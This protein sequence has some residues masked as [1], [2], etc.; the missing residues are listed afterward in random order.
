MEV[1][2]GV[3]DDVGRHTGKGNGQFREV[4]G[5]VVGRRKSIEKGEDVLSQNESAALALRMIAEVEGLRYDVSILLRALAQTLMAQVLPIREHVRPVL[6]P[7]HRVELLRTVA[8]GVEAAH[9]T[10]HRGASDDVDGHAGPLQNFQD[11]DVGNAL[12]AAPTQHQSQTWP[13]GGVGF[14]HFDF[15]TAGGLPCNAFRQ[16]EQ[17]QEKWYK[18]FH[19]ANV[20]KKN[21]T[22]KR[23]T[24]VFLEMNS[25]LPASTARS[26]AAKAATGTVAT[27]AATGT[28]ATIAA[29]ASPTL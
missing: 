25:I 13:L 23:S 21:D 11:A 5:I 15:F 18:T 3:V 20:R 9:D 1:V 17:A 29:T 16:Q 28:V 6:R 8:A 22:A 10:A 4:D 24:H 7:D 14:L 26:V 2:L 27:E 19:S 12:G